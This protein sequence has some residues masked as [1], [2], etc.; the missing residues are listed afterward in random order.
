[1]F[2]FA[3]PLWFLSLIPW[4]LIFVYYKRIK[5][6]SFVF[7]DVSSLVEKGD[8]PSA[9]RRNKMLLR[10]FAILFLIIAMARPQSVSKTEEILTYGVDI[11]LTIDTST[12]MSSLD[13]APNNRLDS[14]KKVVADFISG[15]KNDRIGMVIFAAHSF[16]QC[17]L[18]TDYGM[19]L[20]L[21]DEVQIGKIEDATAIGMALATSIKRLKDSEAK[22]KIIVLLTDGENNAGKIDPIT[23]ANLAKT[24]GIKIYTI[25][26]GKEG[27][28]PVPVQ[29]P[30][31]GRRV[32]MMQTKIDEELLSKIAEITGGI[33]FRA[34]S[35]KMLYNI[36]HQIDKLEK[37]EV[38]VK[39]YFHYKEYFPWV[40][41]IALFFVLLE[42]LWFY[43]LKP[44]FP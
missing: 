36:Y 11:I 25:G 26:V 38:K 12:S 15:R 18:T 21:L 40:V 10:A 4:I 31:F 30:V 1:M 23:A 14:A 43:V 29:D 2:S 22:S 33:Y 8:K 35:E 39:E 9:Y 20:T 16:T 6:G 32:V 5:Y 24:L 42:I 17:P 44:K 28:V 3:S 34:E 7:S 13:F 37:T 27:Q 19:L 41:W